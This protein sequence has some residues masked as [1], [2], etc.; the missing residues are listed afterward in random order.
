LKP[1]ARSLW[2][3]VQ[4]GFVLV[5]LWFAARALAGRWADLRT[6]VSSVDANWPLVLVASL[7]VLLAYAILIETWRAMMR[8]WN[9]S[10]SWFEAS[11]IWFISNLGRYVPGKVWQIAAMS[12]MAQ[13]AGVPVVTAA[14]SSLIVNLASVCTGLLIVLASGSAASLPF[15]AGAGRPLVVALGI[16]LGLVALHFLLPAAIG[17]AA[18]LLGRQLPAARVPARALWASVV[19][20]AAGWVL[21]GVAFWLLARSLDPSTPGAVSDFI[22]VYTASYLAGYLT[23]VAPGGIVVRE[24]VLVQG[25]LALGLAG[26]T[27][28]WVLA[29]ASRLW[30]TILETA[31]GGVLAMA[32]ALARRS[33][34]GPAAGTT[35]GGS[36]PPL[37]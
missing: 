10:L 2:I 6:H 12:V 27:S 16:L 32:G 29:F 18:R 23:P 5:A 33:E 21:Y 20:T 26:E 36:S 35:H 19:G 25:M 11:R 8:S 17:A 31:P 24:V 14:G 15:L 4:A 37:S 28:A 1:A 9:G 7:L 13:R 30:L 3:A 34:S 22:A